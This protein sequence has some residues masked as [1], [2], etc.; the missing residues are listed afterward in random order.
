MLELVAGLVL[1]LGTHSISLVAPAWRDRMAARLGTIGW[2]IAYSLP[3]IGGFVLIVQGYAAARAAPELV[4]ITPAWTRHLAY[5][6]L[7]PA[8][9]LLAAAYLPGRI[10]DAIGHPMLAATLL[11]AVAHLLLPT[12]RADL[13]L[14]GAFGLWAL[15]DWIAAARRPP[16]PVPG[17]P[18]GRYNDLIALIVG[19]GLYTAT[20]LWLHPWLIGVAP[21]G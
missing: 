3:S 13:V 20:A 10:K 6:L 9:V 21:F 16:R 14:F 18:R 7:L 19:V 12:T 17:A 5:T 8:F 4:Y 15:A 1:F 11:W 2:K